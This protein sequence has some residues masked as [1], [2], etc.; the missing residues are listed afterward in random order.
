MSDPAAV[1]ATRTQPVHIPAV[2]ERRRLR[3]DRHQALEGVA[4]SKQLDL[5][6]L[7]ALP[8]DY[9]TFPLSPTSDL[10]ST[11]VDFTWSRLPLQQQQLKSEEPFVAATGFYG[12]QHYPR[13]FHASELHCHRRRKQSA[14]IRISAPK[15]P[16]H[17]RYSDDLYEYTVRQPPSPAVSAVVAFFY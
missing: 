11:P 4:V 5:K 14:P 15:Q 1:I 10:S 17:R 2:S 16:I 9:E 13:I 12:I 8:S 3:R 6:P 7:E